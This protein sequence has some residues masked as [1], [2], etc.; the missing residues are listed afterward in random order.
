V[1]KAAK[2]EP[3]PP[4]INDK[5]Y[6]FGVSA[7]DHE[8]GAII[9]RVVPDSPA[10]RS[11]LDDGTIISL[12][13]GDIITSI[14]RRRIRSEKDFAAAVDESPKVMKFRI[15]NKRDWQEYDCEATLR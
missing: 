15:I 12:E 7:E 8:S 14:N 13:E 3:K 10:T 9:T 11:R 2:V 1:K 4:A 5:P 6:R